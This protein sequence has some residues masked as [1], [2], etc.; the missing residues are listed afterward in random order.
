VTTIGQPST[1]FGKK[2]GIQGAQHPKPYPPNPPYPNPPY[3]NPP[4][5]AIILF[6]NK[7]FYDFI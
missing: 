6:K 3:P 5:Q 7:I 4:Q 2:G 1:H